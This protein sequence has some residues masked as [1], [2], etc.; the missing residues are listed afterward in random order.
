MGVGGIGDEDV[1][2]GRGVGEAEEG[3]YG[4][5]GGAIDGLAEGLEVSGEGGDDGGLA[6]AGGIGRQR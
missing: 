1:G 3:F 6:V 5:G 2:V 4:V